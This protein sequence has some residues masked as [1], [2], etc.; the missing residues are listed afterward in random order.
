MIIL[1]FITSIRFF[2]GQYE[3][4]KA[5]L[6]LIWARVIL[7]VSLMAY[8]IGYD[9]GEACDSAAI[10]ANISNGTVTWDTGQEVWLFEV[11]LKWKHILI[12]IIKLALLEMRYFMVMLNHGELRE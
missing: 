10:S 1:P 2:D 9:E 5:I 4:E 12:C 3:K 8:I 11:V 7:P 6:H